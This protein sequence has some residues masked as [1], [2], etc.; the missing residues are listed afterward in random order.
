M[1][2]EWQTVENYRK[3]LPKY[4]NSIMRTWYQMNAHNEICVNQKR[5]DKQQKHLNDSNFV[6]GA[7]S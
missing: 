2:E 7:E 6:Y 4:K 1:R 5:I 3:Y